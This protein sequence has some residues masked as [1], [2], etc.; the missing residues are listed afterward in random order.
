MGD[1]DVYAVSVAS[2]VK[3]QCK[4]CTISLD[5]L[6]CRQ[7][8]LTPLVRLSSPQ[9]YFTVVVN[10]VQPQPHA[11][12]AVGK[13]HTLLAWNACKYQV[14]TTSLSRL[15]IVESNLSVASAPSS[16]SNLVYVIQSWY[17]TSSCANLGCQCS[18]HALGRPFLSITERTLSNLSNNPSYSVSKAAGFWR[19]KIRGSRYRECEESWS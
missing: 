4:L 1:S 9:L 5:R 17:A 13:S 10:R 7:A 19:L 14:S 11:C 2:C 3:S 6:L 15:L 16:V 12:R 18:R 8:P